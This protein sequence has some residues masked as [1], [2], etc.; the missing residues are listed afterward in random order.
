MVEINDMMFEKSVGFLKKPRRYLKRTVR[1]M[2]YDSCHRTRNYNAQKCSRKCRKMEKGSFARNC[3]A[4]GGLYKCCIRRDKEFCHECRFCCT[5]S[6]CTTKDGSYFPDSSELNRNDMSQVSAKIGFQ[7]DMRMYKAADFRCL[8]PKPS[9]P[10]SQW[11]H[12]DMI[13]YRAA[14]TREELGEAQMKCYQSEL[15]KLSIIQKPSISIISFR[16]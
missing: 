10:S 9:L 6:V 7:T 11:P 1:D 16:L 15:E 8:K 2:G 12:Y 3:T 4:N 13:G 14:Q 5:L